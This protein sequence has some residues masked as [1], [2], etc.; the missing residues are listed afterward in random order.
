MTFPIRV[1]DY[2]IIVSIERNKMIVFV[3]DIGHRSRIYKKI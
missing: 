2:R 1:G 3:I